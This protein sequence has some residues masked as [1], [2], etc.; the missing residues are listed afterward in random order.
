MGNLPMA[1][2]EK[3]FIG[4]RSVS[5]DGKSYSDVVWVEVPRA[6]ASQL[7]EKSQA[8]DAYPLSIL[9][10]SSEGITNAL[11]QRFVNR[12]D[13]KGS[14]A[15]FSYVNTAGTP[16]MQDIAAGK[17][18]AEADKTNYILAEQTIKCHQG[19][20]LSFTMDYNTA[21]D[22]LQYCTFRGYMDWDGDFNFNGG[23]DEVVVAIGEDKASK[24]NTDLK[25]PTTFD[26]TVPA[27]A[28]PGSSRLR[29]V[30][31]DAWFPHPGAS[32]TTA[33]GF[34]IDF[35]V[36][37]TGSNPGRTSV[38]V[39]DQGVADE[40]DGVVPV[41]ITAPQAQVSDAKIDG[42]AIRF[43]NADKVWIFTADGR[44]VKFLRE[45]DPVVSTRNLAPGT[46]LVRMQSGQVQR[47]KKV[48]VE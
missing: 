2:G 28:M 43:E 40:P 20:K 16:Y 32:G 27:D 35:P 21:G 41:G 25:H 18:E 13:V 48:V 10:E 12:L 39:R 22:G 38:D 3:P 14:D 37:I 42:E 15:D 31:S 33:K 7:P 26:V 46:Y 19:Q 1:E 9:N 30:F 11:N 34:T 47:T 4:V 17:S 8:S 24:A 45:Q 6:D 5:I 29:L 44:L 23:N 36:E